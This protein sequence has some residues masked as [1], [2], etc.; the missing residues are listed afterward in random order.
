MANFHDKLVLN[1]YMLS[2]FG[3]D[4]IGKKIIGKKGV[5]IF[6]E[7][8]L[9]SNEGYTEEGNT[10]YLQALI[11]HMYNSDHMT[12]T[13]L[14]TYDENIVRYTKQISEKRDKLITWKYFQYLSLLFT[15]VYLDKYFS[16]KVKLLADLNEYVAEFNSKLTLTG[17]GKKK[18][19]DVFTAS[20]F[21]LESLNK[22]A[23]WNATGSG[24][25]LLMHINIKQYLHYANHYN[26]GHQNKV[27]LITPNEG[28]TKQHLE[29]F[30]LSDIRANNFSRTIL[31]CSRVSRWRF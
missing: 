2:L 12:A 11:A 26:Q 24:K 1:K 29:E 31:E 22:L 5:E 17:T 21:S 20:K 7:L 28:L 25:T 14:Q 23:F 9:S 27:L 19:K 3:I 13:M 15:E 30:K 4:S 16:N 18:D 10:K 8:K 6:T